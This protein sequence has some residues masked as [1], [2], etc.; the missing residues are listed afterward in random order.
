MPQPTSFF[1]DDGKQPDADD[2]WEIRQVGKAEAFIDRVYVAEK[3]RKS[4]DITPEPFR[5]APVA[6]RKIESVTRTGVVTGVLVALQAKGKVLEFSVLDTDTSRF[7]VWPEVA[8]I[9]VKGTRLQVELFGVGRAE[10]RPAWKDSDAERG[11][12]GYVDEVALVSHDPQNIEALVWLTAVLV[13]YG[14]ALSNG[15]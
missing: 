12:I 2:L 1:S 4:I 5:M 7:R 8:A 11:V 15:Y 10:Y 13:E 14:R 9:E 6:R 3:R